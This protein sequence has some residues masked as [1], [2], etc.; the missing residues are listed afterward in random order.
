MLLVESGSA[1]HD[2]ACFRTLAADVDTGNE[3]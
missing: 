1:N 3:S 2:T